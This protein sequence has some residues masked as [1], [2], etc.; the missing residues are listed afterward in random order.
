MS[1]TLVCKFCNQD[2]KI[3]PYRIKDS[4]CCSR[5][6][7]WHITKS[8]RE[9]ARLN[10]IIGKKA[11]N[12]KQIKIHCHE[13]KTPILISPSRL[14]RTKFCN[15]DCYSKAQKT[16]KRLPYK[17]ISI[18]G[19]RVHEH[20]Y[21]MEVFMKRKLLPSEHVHH[22]NGDPLDNR[23]ENLELLSISEHTRRH[24]SKIY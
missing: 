6:C 1:I 18:N 16:P 23:I 22:I 9:P 7:L 2:Y 17:R 5:K 24:H 19:I 12:N 15:K 21:I 10:S 20:R 11:V 13:C 8:Q 3:R 4:I 14:G